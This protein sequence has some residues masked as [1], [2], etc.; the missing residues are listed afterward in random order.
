MSLNLQNESFYTLTTNYKTFLFDIDFQ[1]LF[2]E[3]FLIYSWY[4]FI[5]VWSNF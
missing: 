4:C 1:T 3:I 2:P 5:N